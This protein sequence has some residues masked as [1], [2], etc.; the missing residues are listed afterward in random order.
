[1]VGDFRR[2]G[3][4]FRDHRADDRLRLR[5]RALACLAHHG[6]S[7]I[8]FYIALALWFTWITVSSFVAGG[9]ITGRMRRPIDG[10]TTH[11]RHV[12]DGVHGLVVWAVAVVI[13]TSLATL[14]IASA[15]TT[16]LLSSALKG[17]AEIAKS[18]ASSV[19]SSVASVADPIGYSVD[20]L[21]RI[22]DGALAGKSAAT[23][24]SRQE[25]SR[26]LIADAASGSLSG[27]DRA[28]VA[29]AVATRALIYLEVSSRHTSGRDGSCG[30]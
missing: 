25:I 22:D 19:S 24:T 6:S 21:L 23:E 12:R 16:L 29:R 7:P 13:G 20:N 4:R 11:E 15:V 2:S 17:G 26:I 18:G 5:H 8:I 1:M 9:Y 10:A 3:R 30:L 28:L 14:S 27:N